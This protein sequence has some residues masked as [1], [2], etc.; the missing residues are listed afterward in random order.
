MG[1]LL[2]MKACYH[3]LPVDADTS[4]L[5]GV[6]TQD[7]IY[8]F[9]RMPFGA[10]QAPEWLQFVMDKVLERVLG[11]SFYDDVQVPGTCWW[12]N[13]VD[14]CDTLR[15]LTQAGFMVNLRKCQFLQPRVVM[16]GMEVHRG[17]YRLAKKS[18]KNWLGAELPGNLQELQQVLGRLLWASPFIADFKRKVRPIEALLSPR[19]EG[20]W[21]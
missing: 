5:L 12:R 8:V 20:Q 9:V 6:V 4:E 18:L 13:W 16:V 7:G 10:K 15:A 17:S 3:N 19:S 1:S 11:K 21:T 14:T 2:D